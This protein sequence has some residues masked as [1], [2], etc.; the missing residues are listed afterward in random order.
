M[1]PRTIDSSIAATTRTRAPRIDRRLAVGRRQHLWRVGVQ[2]DEQ[3]ADRRP[4]AAAGRRRRG[5]HPAAGRGWPPTAASRACRRRIRAPISNRLLMGIGASRRP[6]DGPS[7]GVPRGPTDDQGLAGSLRVGPRL[8]LV[9]P[10]SRPGSARRPRSRWRRRYRR[11][12]RQDEIDAPQPHA[13]ARS[14]ER[15]APDEEAQDRVDGSHAPSLTRR[16]RGMWD[17]PDSIGLTAPRRRLHDPRWRPCCTRP[18]PLSL[19]AAAG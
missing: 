17:A 15:Y 2:P 12:R 7:V 4:P 1:A 5:W 18:H 19:S 6:R 13:E 16:A 8:C 9:A 14:G 3:R 11:T 10:R